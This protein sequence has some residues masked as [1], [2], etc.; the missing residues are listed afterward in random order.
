[1]PSIEVLCVGQSEPSEY[2]DLAFAVSADQTCRSHRTRSLFQTDF[3]A[4]RGVLYHLGNPSLKV[5]AEGRFF[6]AYELLMPASQESGEFLEFAADHRPHAVRML[7]DLI[8]RSPAGRLIFTSDWQ[9]GP[10]RATY[11]GR[12]ALAKLWQLH[13]DRRLRFNALY[14]VE[15]DANE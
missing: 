9:F 4:H 14:V 11:P 3:D 8:R 10:E 12:V 15:D 2:E 13:G 6:F 5:D 1:M 7:A